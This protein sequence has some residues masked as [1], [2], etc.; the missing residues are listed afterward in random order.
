[1]KTPALTAPGGR[2]SLISMNPQRSKWS[3]ESQ[4]RS[5]LTFHADSSA[6]GRTGTRTTPKLTHG[7]EMLINHPVEALENRERKI[8]GST[9]LF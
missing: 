6:S 7:A 5:E 3:R 8:Y 2:G 4:E 1:V 9:R